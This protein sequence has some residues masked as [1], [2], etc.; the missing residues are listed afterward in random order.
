MVWWWPRNRDTLWKCLPGSPQAALCAQPCAIPGMDTLMHTHPKEIAL[1]M[2][3][4]ERHSRLLRVSQVLWEVMQLAWI[5]LV[6]SSL[7]KR[8]NSPQQGKV[9]AALPVSLCQHCWPFPARHTIHPYPKICLFLPQNSGTSSA[10]VRSQW[11][12]GS[13]FTAHWLPNLLALVLCLQRVHML[14]CK[15]GSHHA[16]H[17]QVSLL[18]QRWDVLQEKCMK[19]V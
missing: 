19:E 4:K 12:E 1:V 17:R 16:K 8:M 7:C 18:L 11:C 5:R 2:W 6:F 3:R 15:S 13:D 9:R 14:W 10:Y